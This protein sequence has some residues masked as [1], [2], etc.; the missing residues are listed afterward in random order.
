MCA[1]ISCCRGCGATAQVDPEVDRWQCGEC[2]AMVVNGININMEESTE[3]CHFHSAYRAK[4]PPR[5]DCKRCWEI[6]QNKYGS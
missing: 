6:W 2:T 4:K 3:R 5:S 1:L